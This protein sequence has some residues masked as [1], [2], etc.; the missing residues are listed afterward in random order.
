MAG[1]QR[2]WRGSEEGG[3]GRVSCPLRQ[4]VGREGVVATSGRQGGGGAFFEIFFLII[5]LGLP[6]IKT[7][8]INLGARGRKTFLY[9]I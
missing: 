6:V 9:Y 8:Q 1:R 4:G 2:P 3:G 5:D 7:A